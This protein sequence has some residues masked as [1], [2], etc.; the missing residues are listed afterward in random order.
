MQPVSPPCTTLSVVIMTMTRSAVERYVHRFLWEEDSSVC[1]EP[2]S[3]SW[4]PSIIQ[5]DWKCFQIDT[6]LQLPGCRWN[7]SP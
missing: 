3:A 7:L 1:K 5:R 4:E 6:W 2:L